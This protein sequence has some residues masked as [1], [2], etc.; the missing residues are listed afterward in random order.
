MGEHWR[1][2]VCAD[3][4]LGRSAGTVLAGA[5]AL[6]PGSGWSHSGTAPDPALHWNFD[7]L[8]TML[9]GL[10]AALYGI[11]TARLWAR[12]GRGRGINARHAAAFATGALVTAAA[13]VSP[14][15]DFGSRSLWG[16]MVQHGLLMLLAAPLFVCARP[17]QAWTWA[18]EPAWRRSAGTAARWTGLRAAWRGISAPIPA[19]LLHAAVLWTWHAPALFQAALTSNAVHT[20]QHTSFLAAALLYWW[21]VIGSAARGRGHGAAAASLFTTMLHTGMLGALL[22]FSGRVWYPAYAA[23]AGGVALALE[24]QRLAGLIMWIPGGFVYMLAALAIAAHGL[25]QG[26]GGAAAPRA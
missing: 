13:L 21:S 19:W 4:R 17:L 11:G 20:L 1:C 16:H 15:D 24:D 10:A 14:L 7:P 6:T 18:L 2:A 8:V 9:L 22:T 23:G 3:V 26:L 25:S 12:A 5:L